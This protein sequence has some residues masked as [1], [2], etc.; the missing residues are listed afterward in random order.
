MTRHPEWRSRLAAHLAAHARI[1]FRPGQHDC[2]LFAAGARLAVRGE[3]LIT[4]FKGRYTTIE[5]GFALAV[6][7]GFADPFE[8]VVAGLEEIP[9][10]FA[11][12]GDLALLEGTDGL[13]A[14]GIVQGAMIACLH[15]RGAGL[16]PIT[17]ARRV[18]RQ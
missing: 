16:V 14:M 1:A 6:E 18:W 12:V 13:P 17:E 3:D 10:A 2:V 15:P 4:A 9:P 5:E 8:G 11:Q 7:A